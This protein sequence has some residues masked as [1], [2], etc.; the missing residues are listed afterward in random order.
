MKY[1]KSVL[2]LKI[3]FKTLLYWKFSLKNL[4]W[5]CF[6]WKIRVRKV[7]L[8]M[9]QKVSNSFDNLCSK[10]FLEKFLFEKFS[11]KN[12]N[13]ESLLRQRVSFKKFLARVSVKSVLMRASFFI[14]HLL[15]IFSNMSKKNLSATLNSKTVVLSYVDQS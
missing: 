13:S 15:L 9:V 6:S 14:L 4:G 8:R 1:I 10:V 2:G 7:F 3:N 5:K 12:F 11:L